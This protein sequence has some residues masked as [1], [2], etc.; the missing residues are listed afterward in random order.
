MI[1]RT[2]QEGNVML[3]LCFYYEDAEARTAL[4]DAIAAEFP[5]ITSLFYVING[6]A[7]DSIS[8]QE[9][10]LYKGE[11]AIYEYMEG[12]KFKIGPKSFYQTNTKQAYKLYS[13]ARE[14]AELTGNEVVYDLYTG[15][16]TIA[17]FVSR[18][19]S[20]VIG[21]EYVPEAIEDA[22]VNAA[23]NNIT[24][25]DFYAGDMKDILT[26]EVVAEHGHPDVIILDPPRAG[27]HPDVAQVILNAA[28]DRMVYVSC[29]PASQ[30]RDLEILCKDYVI[31][32]V[33]PVD[34]FPHTH[35]VENVVALKRK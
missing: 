24:N 12:L 21:I 18:Q 11:D 33:R 19:A 31:T 29:N 20:K 16:G 22:K 23:N 14:Y 26:D 13:V 25:C 7:N 27:I 28:P 1:V 32:A 5:Q 15:T 6:K 30:A 34:M 35:H 9:C 3:I 10:V 17:Q 4:L 2:T 8:D